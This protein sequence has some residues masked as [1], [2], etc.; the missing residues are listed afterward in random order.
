MQDTRILAARK[1]VDKRVQFP[2]TIYYTKRKKNPST[3][4]QEAVIHIIT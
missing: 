1:S 2:I 3:Y 4:I